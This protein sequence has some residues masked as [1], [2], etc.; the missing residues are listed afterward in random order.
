VIPLEEIS[1]V[2]AMQ[3]YFSTPPHAKKL[4]IREFKELTLKD[5]EELREM[6][7]GAGYNVAPLPVQIP[8]SP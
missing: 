5:R 7:I 8:V 1:F 4:E 6:L 3:G 2:K